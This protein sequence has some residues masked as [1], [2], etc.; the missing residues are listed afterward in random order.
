MTNKLFQQAKETQEEGEINEQ[1]QM[2]DRGRSYL[3]LTLKCKSCADQCVYRVK[4]IIVS[5]IKSSKPI[6]LDEIKCVN[7]DKLSEFE[8][9][10][11]GYGTLAEEITRFQMLSA[12]KDNMEAVKKS[13]VKFMSIN[14]KGTEMGLEEG[15]QAIL[16]AI[17]KDPS[18]P[19]NYISLTFIFNNIK[20]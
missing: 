9:T 5:H 13:P 1:G 18:N 10:P 6:I 7:C 15:M 12:E 11:Q 2:S 14:V 17:A 4:E 8:L 16:D 19:E 20:R 3:D